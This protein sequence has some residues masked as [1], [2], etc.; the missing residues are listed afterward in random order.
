VNVDK[1][2]DQ[3]PLAETVRANLLLVEERIA[4]ACQLAGRSRSS[5]RLLAVS[6]FNPPEAVLAAWQA[7]L[8]LFGENRV[9]E[10]MTKFAPYDAAGRRPAALTE[11]A[12]PAALAASLPGVE[13][14]LLGHLQSNKAAKAVQLFDC[15]QSVDSPEI[16]TELARQAAKAGRVLDVLFELHTG[17]ESKSGF[18]DEPALFAALELAGSLPS[19]RPRGLM[20][21]APFTTDQAAIQRSFAACRQSMERAAE[22]FRFPAFDVLSM[23]MTNDFELA[24]AEGASLL[25]IGTAIFGAR[26]YP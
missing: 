7:G 17:E 2:T 21:M 12:A 4:R 18:A 15:V 1:A 3:N 8:R 16:L 25:R 22:R 19:L 14:H 10:A 5:L 13:V 26:Q 24:I 9:Q 6:K 11:S 20:T 23:G